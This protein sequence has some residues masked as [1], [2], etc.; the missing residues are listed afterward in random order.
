MNKLTEMGL[1]ALE[2][3]LKELTKIG[4][5]PEQRGNDELEELVNERREIER[6]LERRK[7]EAQAEERA[8]ADIANSG[9]VKPME[10]FEKE[11]RKMFEVNSVEYRDAW[12]T[13]MA[14]KKLSEEQ[15]DAM[16]SATSSGG[17]AIPTILVDKIY[18]NM[19]QIAPMLAEIDVMH[20][21]GNI[22]LAI[23]DTV[24]AA[25]K[26]TEGA[27][28]T[29][30]SDTITKISLGGYELVKVIGISA[31]LENMSIDALEAWIVSNLARKLA[32]L[33]ENY[34]INGSGSSEPAGID[35]LTW[36]T[37]N[38][39]NCVDWAG[40]APTAAELISLIG[41]LNAAY[42]Q[43]AKFLMNWKTFWTEVSR[44]A[45]KRRNLW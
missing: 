34:V 8:C 31:K 19:V 42:A 4:E 7:A 44:C 39:T 14:G 41:K 1:E 10:S 3:R 28:I 6:E 22:T 17:Y 30:A 15:R 20:I 32:E 43:D 45:M 29:P 13:A 37:S 11:S 12:L 16:T 33:I 9:D 40:T 38:F 5:N 26:H 27:T 2:E 24:N 36:D 25:A 23:E 21:P 18:E 35:S